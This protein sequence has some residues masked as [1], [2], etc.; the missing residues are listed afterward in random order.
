MGNGYGNT[1]VFATTSGKYLGA[2]IAARLSVPLGNAVVDRFNDGEVHVQIMEN[3]RDHDVFIVAPLHAPAENFFEAVLLADAASRSSAAR[4]TYVI[5]YMGYTRADRKSA[6]RM[7]IGI[8][9][10]FQVILLGSPH[11]MIILDV[12]ADQ[13][14]AIV[15]NSV[16]TDHLYGSSALLPALKSYLGESDFIVASPDKGGTTRAGFYAKHLAGSSDFAILSKERVKAGEVNRESIK[17][18]GEVSG[19]VVVF[20]DDMIDTGGTMIAGAEAVKNA[21]ATGVVVCATHG[22]FSKNAMARLQASEIDRIF[23]TDSIWHEKERIAAECPKIEVVSVAELLAQA[24][25]R[26][27]EGESLSALIP[28]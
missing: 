3:V 27:H 20:V 5:P 10:A 23:V 1:R 28:D 15:P 2:E 6:S 25:R 8:V 9:I 13:S 7:P 22:L 4:V 16:G 18:I 24:I 11:R 12:H 26:T 19:K 14:L 17:I 21:G